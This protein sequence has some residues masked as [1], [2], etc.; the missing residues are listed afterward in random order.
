MCLASTFTQ[1]LRIQRAF[2]YILIFF[3]L[4]WASAAVGDVS[5]SSTSTTFEL[6]SHYFVSCISA[7]V[8][9]AIATVLI[10]AFIYQRYQSATTTTDSDTTASMLKIRAKSKG[11]TVPTH[12]T[13]NGDALSR[14]L[15]AQGKVRNID[16][17]NQSHVDVSW[18]SVI[19]SVYSRKNSHK[20]TVVK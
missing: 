4:V 18:D 7:L 17:E 8:L 2:F 19:S 3:C 6:V 10:F 16:Y 13:T 5:T 20:Q 11:E 1:F 15:A 14:Q 12:R 9:S